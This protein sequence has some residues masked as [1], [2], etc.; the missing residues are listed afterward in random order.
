MKINRRDMLKGMALGAGAAFGSTLFPGFAQAAATSGA[1]V[2]RGTAKRVI[3]FLQNQGFDP[4]TAIPK[5][6][7]ES[8]ALSGVTLPEPI[9]ALEAYKAC[10]IVLERELGIAPAAPTQARR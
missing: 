8:V 5:G 9:R 2:P 7:R 1:A 3:F 10:Q 6:L 4:A